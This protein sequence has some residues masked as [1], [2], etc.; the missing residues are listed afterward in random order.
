MKI[1]K[2][3]EELNEAIMDVVGMIL[4]GVAALALCAIIYWI[5]SLL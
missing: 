2:L 1:L 3:I 4:S 5:I